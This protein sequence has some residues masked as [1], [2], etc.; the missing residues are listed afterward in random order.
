MSGHFKKKI[1]LPLKCIYSIYQPKRFL[2]PNS[3]RKGFRQQPAF[4][5]ATITAIVGISTATKKGLEVGV[6]NAG[7]HESPHG[8]QCLSVWACF[9]KL[10][11]LCFRGQSGYV[12]GVV[13]VES[14]QTT[15]YYHAMKRP[16]PGK[17]EK[18][19]EIYK[20]TEDSYKVMQSTE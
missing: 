5:A 18:K 12:V 15:H 6:P 8:L 11:A 1:M 17:C 4:F 13:P 3:S 7:R 9:V 16:K 10:P 19:N 2:G 14:A 20:K